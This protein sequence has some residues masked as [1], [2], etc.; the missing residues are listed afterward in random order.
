MKKE[1]TTVSNRKLFLILP[2]FSNYSKMNKEK[3]NG[4]ENIT[5]TTI[6]IWRR[7]SKKL[8]FK[9]SDR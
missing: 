9:L 4:K 6:T 7:L 3:V 2:A 1:A 5:F 8:A